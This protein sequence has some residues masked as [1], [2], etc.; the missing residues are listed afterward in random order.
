MTP[1]FAWLLST[2]LVLRVINTLLL[3]YNFDTLSDLKVSRS[4]KIINYGTNTANTSSR[5]ANKE[6]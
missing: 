6:N 2:I 4:K 1:H 5:L 3:S